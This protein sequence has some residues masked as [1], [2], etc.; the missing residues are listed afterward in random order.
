MTKPVFKVVQEFGDEGPQ[1]FFVNDIEVGYC[2]HDTS[3]WE[4]MQ[5]MGE[6]FEAI[7]AELGVEVITE[8]VEH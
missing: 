1:T 4:G 6:M 8:D 5:A 7:A 3:G 2:D